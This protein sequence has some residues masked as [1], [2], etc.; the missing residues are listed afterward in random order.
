MHFSSVLQTAIYLAVD[1]SVFFSLTITANWALE[2]VEQAV[3][4]ALQA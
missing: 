1:C 4:T 2:G 3:L